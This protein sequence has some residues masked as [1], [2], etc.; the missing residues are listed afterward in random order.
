M[1]T[2][3]HR[4]LAL[5]LLESAK[6]LHLFDF[7]IT[8][9]DVQNY[10]PHPETF[11]KC[12]QNMNVLPQFCQVFEDGRLGI[13]AGHAAGMIV[14]DVNRITSYNVCYTKLLRCSRV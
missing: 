3:S 2:G 10:K 11:L 5:Q 4:K 9:D 14:T 1:G 6:L 12:A 8:A 13:E 7:I